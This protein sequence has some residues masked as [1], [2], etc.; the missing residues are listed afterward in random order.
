[1]SAQ[2]SDIN[3]LAHVKY[4]V[5]VASGKGGV[6]KS[7]V[8]A[9]LALSLQQQ[10]FKV[11]LLD[12]DIYGPSQAL[13]FGV[14]ANT[15]PSMV[16][17]GGFM[18]IEAE[19]IATMSMA[20]LVTD[21]TPMVWRGPM[22]SGA[23]Q[24]MLL[25]TA[26]GEL[27]I[28]LVDLPPGTGDIQLTLTQRVPMA[29]AVVITTPQDLAVLDAQKAIE[30]FRKVNVPVLGLI[31]N[32]SYHQCSACGQQDHIFGIGGGHR[33]EQCYDV[34]LL[35]CLPLSADMQVNDQQPL[36]LSTQHLWF[37]RINTAAQSLM[38]TLVA[39][40]ESLPVIRDLDE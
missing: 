11:G 17:G 39:S 2:T 36:T 12:A 4:I 1:M 26:W 28:L 19:G 8:A 32:M 34:P 7:T 13:L 10:G 29:G 40:N 18:P 6:G 16:A 14:V 20:Y 30:M 22:A 35:T 37:D 24:Q 25:Q 23:L 38:S 5:G 33:L 3:N 31:E 15:R 21:K 27:D 9:A